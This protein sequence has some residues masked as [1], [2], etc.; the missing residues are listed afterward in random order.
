MK[1]T[2]E[3]VSLGVENIKNPFV[4]NWIHVKTQIKAQEYM[5]TPFGFKV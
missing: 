2:V 5:T 3:H 1:K 4:N